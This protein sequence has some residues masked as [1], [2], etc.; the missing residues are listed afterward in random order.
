MT[1]A[2]AKSLSPI[3]GVAAYQSGASYNI[4][5][6]RSASPATITSSQPELT[7]YLRQLITLHV[8]GILNDEEFS[9]AR[10]RLLGS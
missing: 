8:A 1:A 9:A 6:A 5:H 7:S 4:N 10:G 2:M 3:D